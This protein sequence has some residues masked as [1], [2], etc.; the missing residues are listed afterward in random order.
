VPP[1]VAVRGMLT[2]Y[3]R[4]RG[5]KIPR[6]RPKLALLPWSLI[7]AYQGLKEEN[8]DKKSPGPPGWRLMQQASPLFIEKQEISKKPVRNTLHRCNL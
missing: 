6:G 3:G 1:P 8:L 4:Y 2:R 7:L 5:N